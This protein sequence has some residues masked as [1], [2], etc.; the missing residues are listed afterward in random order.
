MHTK[1]D[2]YGCV[3][4]GFVGHR[5]VCGFVTRLERFC[6]SDVNDHVVDDVHAVS[7][8]GGVDDF[9]LFIAQWG[10]LA[11]RRGCAHFGAPLCGVCRLGHAGQL[12]RCVCVAVG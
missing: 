3:V 10:Q 7:N 5:G 9:T 12:A 4:V 1:K 11:A 2:D 8:R 6:V